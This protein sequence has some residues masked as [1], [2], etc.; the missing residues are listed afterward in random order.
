MKTSVTQ[1]LCGASQILAKELANEI[2]SIVE[3]VIA[4]HDRQTM[5]S[6]AVS[7]KASNMVENSK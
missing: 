4:Y 5:S 7:R 2:F 1:L 3:L 6:I